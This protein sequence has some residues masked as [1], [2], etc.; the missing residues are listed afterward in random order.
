M[1]LASLLFASASAADLDVELSLPEADPVR[2]VL[3][4]VA[5]GPMPG[6]L[7]Q[8]RDGSTY[9]VGTELRSGAPDQHQV[10]FVIE[11]LQT[12]RKGRVQTTLVAQPTLN[13]LTNQEAEFG[14]GNDTGSWRV[15]VTV[16][17]QS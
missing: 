14:V 6:L 1:L 10:A 11:S 4:D 7:V 2:V 13:V 8:A 17:D 3:A 12:D 5:D 16:R 9:R 15:R